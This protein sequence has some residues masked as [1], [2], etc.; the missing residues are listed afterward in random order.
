MRASPLAASLQCLVSNVSTVNENVSTVH[1]DHR[2]GCD[3]SGVNMASG[4]GEAWYV[5]NVK[6]E[7]DF[8]GEYFLDVEEK[9]LYYVFNGTEAP[10]GDEDFSLIT[11]K[12]VFN[13]SGTQAAPVKGVTLR[14]LTI[15]DAALTYLGTSV[16]DV[17]YIPSDSDWAI[18]RGGAVLL[19]GTE[20][21]LFE[22]NEVTRC[23]GNG[24][25]LSNYN[26]NASLRH[27]EFSWIGA[28][29]MQGFGSMGRCLY[30]NCSVRL[31]FTSGLDG[32]GG[33]Q[34]RYTK[35]VGNL[36]REIGLHQKQS[37]AWASHLAA[38][39]LLE[40]NVFMNMPQTAIGFNDGAR[41]RVRRFESNSILSVDLSGP[42]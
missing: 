14:G 8:P 38:R 9:A 24:V 42:G 5:D 30:A 37:A 18:N 11:T 31:N 40:S 21:F 4:G 32:R 2:L 13:V 35:I 26:R 34:P 19:E 22:E 10:G 1:F 41:C 36:V 39:T 28:S 16:A 23:D 27:N 33:N 7:T 12:V 20:D 25:F 17:H 15:R 3:Q 29:A 6:E